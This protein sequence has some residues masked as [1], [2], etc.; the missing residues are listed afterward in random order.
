MACE[1]GFGGTL[2]SLWGYLGSTCGIWGDFG[3]ILGSVWISVDDF[4]TL[5][6]YFAMI[7]ESLRVYEGPFSKAIHFPLR[8]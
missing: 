6:G 5:H 8:F 3:V 4:G 2:G 7:V 1:D